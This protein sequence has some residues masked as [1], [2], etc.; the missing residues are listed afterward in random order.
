M[1]NRSILLAL[2]L[3]LTLG[4]CAAPAAG[5]RPLALGEA[6]IDAIATLLRLEDRREF[7]E[8]LL[9]EIT[10]SPVVEVRRRAAL[11]AG[12]I[13][14]PGATPLLLPLLDDPDTAVA[15][16][17]AFALG[18]QGDTSAVAPL[19]ALLTSEAIRRT[20]TVAAEAASAL[21]KLRG[22][23]AR[24]ALL[25]VLRDTPLIDQGAAEAVGAALLAI[26]KFP[27]DPDLEPIRRWTSAP[28][29]Q[30]RW[31]AVYA[32]VRRPDPA[33]TAI[34]LGLASDP[35]PQ[36]RSLAMRGLTAPLADS[37]GVGAAATLPVV[38]AASRDSDY[39]VR[40]NAVRALGSYGDAAAVQ[41][42]TDLLNASQ[43]HLALAAAES[44]ERLGVRAA[45]AAPALR[46]AA[47]DASQP[48]AIRTATLLALAQAAPREAEQV[49]ATLARDPH[50]RLRAAAGRAYAALDPRPGPALTALLRD[51][52]PRVGAGVLGAA[53]AAAGDSAAPLRSLLIEA[54]GASDVML[55]TAAIGGL[56]RLA[57]PS[58]APLL[59]DAYARAQRDTLNDAA[60]AAVDAL[61]ALRRAGS[62]TER[63]F[64]Q[65]FSRPDDYLVRQRVASA[66]GDAARTAW[67]DPLPIET[68]LSAAEYR[69]L[70][71]EWIAPELARGSPPRVRLETEAGVIDLE[72]FA[73]E[74][75]LTV[76]S[77]LTLAERG[78]FDEQR[79]PRVVPNFV[80]QGGDPR[81]DQTGGPGYAIRDEINRH[82]YE[83]GTLGMALSGP[84]TGGSQF[85]ITHS[86][87]PHLDGGYT[88]FGRVLSGM[89]VVE[90]VLPDERILS[91][92]RI[93]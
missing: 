46:G 85:F 56:A 57:D 35:E 88:V 20:P 74:A 9:R 8:G 92:R 25:S 30:L 53:V 70:V 47:L 73:S 51:P 66:F 12:R 44:L 38:L 77:F 76:R 83:R 67:G 37:A 91:V 64:L 19:A 2:V 50:W 26:W 87:Q 1:P 43:A 32:L 17:A 14:H 86:P 93:P 21:G 52:D 28:D 22:E 59:L 78:Y 23:P 31:R 4:A 11:A 36:V 49:A 41:A 42:L 24:Q 39:L 18:Q 6:E 71:Q 79:W 84:D 61:A 65:R 34:L 82:R 7:D 81:G 72:L 45:S 29:P 10:A 60:L 75:P 63:A 16:T 90:R 15:A 5:P 89:E 54:L 3:S 48:V 55:R 58:T 69:A 40:V 27:R 68:G 80:I 62:A 33:A 13:R